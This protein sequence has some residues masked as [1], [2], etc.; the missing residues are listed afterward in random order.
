MGA[1][2]RSLNGAVRGLNSSATRLTCGATTLSVSSHLVPIVNS[3]LVKPVRLPSSP[4][5]DG[6]E[7]PS[8]PVEDGR[9]TPSW[10]VEDGRETPFCRPRLVTRPDPTGPVTCPNA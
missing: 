6:R 4:V 8:W 2:N 3:K 9:E 7:T 1:Q 5:E 10:P